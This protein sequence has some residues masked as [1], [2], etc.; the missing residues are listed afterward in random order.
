[1]GALV[2]I[3]LTF[4]IGIICGAI[5]LIKIGGWLA[6]LS[7]I[8]IILYYFF[9]TGILVCAITLDDIRKKDKMKEEAKNYERMGS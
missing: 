1:M 9:S 3:F 8:L 5:I 6:I 7:A 4:F 2:L